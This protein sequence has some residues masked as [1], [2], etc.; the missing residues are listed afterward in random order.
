MSQDIP[1]LPSLYLHELLQGA[2]YFSSI[3][4]EVRYSRPGI[5]RK[6]VMNMSIKS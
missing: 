4:N 6:M 3:G 5:R 1:L 2:L